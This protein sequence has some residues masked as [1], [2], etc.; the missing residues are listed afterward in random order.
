[1]HNTAENTCNLQIDLL[2]L[3]NDALE[4]CIYRHEAGAKS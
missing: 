3:E 2:I 1:M 4:T